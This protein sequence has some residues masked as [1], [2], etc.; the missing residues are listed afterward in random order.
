MSVRFSEKKSTIIQ[1]IC[2]LDEIFNAAD[3]PDKT[4]S[5]VYLDFAKAFDKVTHSKLLSKLQRIGIGGNLFR[6]IKSYLTNRKQ[7][8][9]LGSVKS[10]LLEITSG[11][12]QGSL[13]GPLLFLIYVMDLPVGISTAP[14]MFADDSKLLDILKRN[15]YSPAQEDVTF[16]YYSHT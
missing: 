16:V 14:Y 7:Y 3:D 8:V 4:V 10:S 1:L 5:A 13:L 6:V 9:Q 12:P 11:V 15:A 2:Y